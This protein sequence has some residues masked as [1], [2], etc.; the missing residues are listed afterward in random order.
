MFLKHQKIVEIANVVGP[1]ILG[2]NCKVSPSPTAVDNPSPSS[3]TEK[4]GLEFPD[5]DKVRLSHSPP[6]C[7][8]LTL[9]PSLSSVNS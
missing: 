7:F 4:P 6:L 8:T 9:P 1:S 2:A 3:T 5:E